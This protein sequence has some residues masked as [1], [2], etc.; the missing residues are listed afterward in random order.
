MTQPR[1]IRTLL[2]AALLGANALV[3]ALCVY[4]LYQSRQLH[5]LRAESLVRN[6]A[7]AVEQSISSSVGKIDLALQ[8][9]VDELEQQLLAKGL[10]P[11]RTNRFFTRFEQRMPEV[12]G[13]RV[14][15]AEGAVV[16]GKGVTPAD[17]FTAEDRDY[18]LHYKGQDDKTLWITKP[19]WGRVV[20]HYIIIF[21][22]RYNQPNGDFAG[23]VFATVSS[24][25]FTQLLSKFDLGPRG[26]V[27]LRDADV[28]LIVRYPPIPDKPAGKVGSSD[29]SPELRQIIASGV[30]TATYHAPVSADGFERV[31]AF[32]RL[33]NIPMLVN[34]GVASEDYLADWNQEKFKT[35][36]L[37]LAIVAM[38][39]A[40]GW[41][42]LRLLNQAMRESARN[43]IYLNSAA[44][45]VLVMSAS[46]TLIEVNDRFCVLSGYPRAEL[47]AM[48]EVRCAAC[49]PNGLLPRLLASFEPQTLETRLQCHSGQALDVELNFSAFA[50]DGEKHLYVSVRDITERKQNETALRESEERFRTAFL[51]SPDAVNIT[52]LSDGRYLEVNDAFVHTMGW[53]REETVGRSSLDMNIWHSA[54]DRQRLVAALQ[55]DGHYDNLEAEFVAKDGRIITGL[56]S[57]HVIFLKGE[58]CLLSVT[59]DITERKVAENQLRK[60]SMAVEQSSDSVVITDLGG[61][62]EYVN[63]TFV[64]NTGYSREEALGKNPRVLQSGRTPAQTYASL[65]DAMTEGRSW[66]GEFY[67]QR[68]DG[69]H[70]IEWAVISPIRQADGRITHYVAVKSDITARKEAEER[71]NNLAF[72]DPLTGLPNRRLL[73]DRLRHAVASAKRTD[74]HGALLFIDLDNFKTL[75]DSLGHDIGDLL[76]R[77]TAQR[78]LGCVREGDTVARLGGDEFVVL[79]EHVSVSV[80][81]TA[82]SAEAVAGKILLA[83]NQSY[84]L[85]SFTCHSSASI[86]VTLFSDHPGSLEDL[87]KRA[88]LAMYQAK[89]A[90]RN[91]MRFFDPQMQVAVT[92]RAALE[93][94]L[95]EALRSQQFLL[96]YQAQV[97][98]NGAITGVEALLRWLHPRRGLVSPAE[99]ISLAEDTGLIVP[100]GR[101]VLETA[102]AQLSAWA[103]RTPMRHLNM[104]VNVSARQFYSQDFVEQV[105]QVLDSSGAAPQRLKLEL[106]ES[107]LVTN[108]EDV[109]SK[110]RTLK[111][112]GVC[113]SLDDFGTGYSSL[114]YLKRLPLDQLKIDQSFVRDI[115]IDPNDAAIAKMVVALADSLGLAVIAEGVESAE[116][117]SFLAEL[118]CHAY[119]GYLFSR[120]LPLVEFEQLAARR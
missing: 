35:T 17:H 75:N 100:I 64:L 115:L 88:D 21:A 42:L 39:L 71:I 19:I 73:L 94:D 16:I 118:G 76:L 96:F 116:Q 6:V 89:T 23:V 69:S 46:G 1:S 44:E 57:A 55:R 92:T 61:K 110:M 62:I 95:R 104:A 119:Q 90:G 67:N 111:A 24:D 91:A 32:H 28:G 81:D 9:A 86:G 25:H 37:V 85:D 77:Q 97:D 34:A 117:R 38:G 106:T 22:R 72:F 108:I 40:L 78:L 70:Y 26:T 87:L 36:G 66:S 13:F 27:V 98:G 51:T 12:E 52:R 68:K 49:W 50:L 5:Q 58:K 65:W 83:L 63:E 59:R 80:Q 47:L 103:L 101:W 93:E 30:N 48:D 11:V 4:S 107:L 99:F 10:D 60:L 45:G 112:A 53:A 2:I 7:S 33:S 3:I 109:I 79:L 8:A 20:K 114:S 84:Q 41:L 56:M 29:V 102:C 14:A 74:R 54:D 113:F 15:N 31:H 82:G 120:P 18:F 43:R 105:M